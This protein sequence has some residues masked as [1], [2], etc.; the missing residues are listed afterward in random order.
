V[1]TTLLYTL[2]DFAHN[3]YAVLALVKEQL[4][5]SSVTEQRLRGHIRKPILASALRSHCLLT[6]DIFDVRKL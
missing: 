2:L 6:R 1:G 3:Y 4:R 5:I